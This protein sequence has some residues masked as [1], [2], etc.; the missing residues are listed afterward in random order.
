MKHGFRKFLALA[1]VLVLTLALFAGC[2]QGEKGEKGDKGDTGAQGIQGEKGDKGDKGDTGAPG[3]DGADGVNGKDGADGVNGKD[4]IDGVNGK[5]GIDGV[6]GK[7]GADGADGKDGADGVNG[8]D[9]ID[10]ADG[11]DGV[12]PQLRVNEEN[13][14][15]EVSYDEGAT[16]LSL[17]IPATGEKGEAGKDGIDGTNGKD[18]IDGAPGK[19]G[20]DGT[21]GKD[22]LD[23]TNGKDGVNGKDGADGVNGLSAYE[24]YK[25]YHPEYGGTE[26]EWIAA[27]V[28]GSFTTYTVTFDLNGGE[29]GEDFLPTVTAYAGAT[30]AL[31]EPTKAGYLFAGWYTGESVNDGVFTTTDRVVSEMTL[32]ARW[33]P[34]KMTVTFLDYYGDVIE[35]QTVDYATAATAPAVPTTVTTDGGILHFV[36]WSAALDAVTEDL[37]VQANYSP[38]LYTVKFVAEGCAEIADA[39][40]AAGLLP[41]KPAD[42][43]K[44]GSIFLGWYLDRAFDEE[45]AFDRA[46]NADTT[47]Y[48]RFME[49]G[50]Y[51][52]VS[53]A[54]DLIAIADD[55]AGTY[56]L[57]N[58]INLKGESWTPLDSFS[59]TLDGAGHKI[60]NFVISESAQY[61]GFIRQNSGTVK[62]LTFDDFQFT[63]NRD[64][65]SNNYIGIIAA[66]NI[67]TISNCTLSNASMNVICTNPSG[68]NVGNYCVG[69][70]CGQNEPNGVVENTESF[71]TLDVYVK[72][73]GGYYDRYHVWRHSYANF[74]LGSVV[75]Y[76]V[77][78]IRDCAY[79]GE[80]IVEAS[81]QTQSTTDALVGGIV[82]RQ[83]DLGTTSRCNAEVE[84]YVTVDS[85]EV[86]KT[87][88][89]GLC[90]DNYGKISECSAIGTISQKG[91]CGDHSNLGGL[92]GRNYNGASVYA[93]YTDVAL[94]A[95]DTNNC[96]IGG[97]VG[98]NEA[99]AS[100]KMSVSTGS[101]TADALTGY[102]YVVGYMADGA[103]CF[104]CYYS[105]ESAITV[106]E[107]QVTEVTCTEGIGKTLA[108]CG[109]RELLF[110]T[111]YWDEAVWTIV[112]GR[113]TLR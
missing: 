51:T 5:D 80:M 76:N 1:M 93:C 44:E 58:D 106:G 15:W 55:P 16:W 81:G 2:A 49:K 89:G 42:P 109:S 57:A 39:V 67:G 101:I 46:L 63:T 33:N 70:V 75:G 27:I 56:I 54:E 48:A 90:G 31:S 108:E 71:V 66:L 23:G 96:Y 10:G 82:G 111:L 22:G 17:N 12:T 18:G 86:T 40:V 59:G 64:S 112:D 91:K 107:E 65:G 43:E 41:E 87:H 74:F 29:A 92:V 24:L 53:S 9:G 100:A 98:Y 21:N 85:T 62:D 105:T 77:G 32:V 20:I 79:I 50:E 88:I 8:K 36:G 35:R 45:Y 83:V 28:S 102:G 61:V 13:N 3:K 95:N 6:P 14:L 11:K 72:A 30:I 47:L 113:P 37:T 26:E 34:E 104:K 7:D 52:L 25:K 73:Q 19:D 78:V 38:D 103:T 94:N 68:N 69:T 84:I 60:C 99:N 4:G 110:E 97:L